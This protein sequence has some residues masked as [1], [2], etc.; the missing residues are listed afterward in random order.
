MKPLTLRGLAAFAAAAFLSLAAHA[1][2]DAAE[3][4]IQSASA[5]PA[6]LASVRV[7]ASSRH[8]ISLDAPPASTKLLDHGGKNGTPLK[9]GF[10]RQ[11][12]WERLEDGGQVAALSITSP[13][14]AGL[15]MGLVVESLPEAAMLRFYAPD[16]APLDVPAAD[17]LKVIALNKQSGVNGQ[18]ARTYWSPMVD[19]DT[20]AL[21]IEIPAHVS[22]LAVRLAM[23]TVSHLESGAPTGISSR[24]NA[25]LQGRHVK[26]Q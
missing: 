15:R 24:Q 22:A 8:V 5:I 26:G 11:L 1:A 14:A 16:A 7:R 9:V 6:T 25:D 13:G 20:I 19:G 17:V 2:P 10:A 4:E 21:E 12:A 3:P 23:P 18:A